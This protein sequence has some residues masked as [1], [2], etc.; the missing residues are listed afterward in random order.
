MVVLTTDGVVELA[1]FGLVDTVLTGGVLVAVPADTVVVGTTGFGVVTDAVEVTG[2]VTPGGVVVA[3]P[4]TVTVLCAGL[5]V[6]CFGVGVVCVA[7]VLP[8]DAGMYGLSVVV[9][10]PVFG[11]GVVVTAPV[12]TELGNVVC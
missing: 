8:P 3:A 6:V 9:V 2:V 11:T 5:G 7:P 10:C 4:G 12:P 1:A